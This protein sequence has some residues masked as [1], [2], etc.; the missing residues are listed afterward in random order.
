MPSI[1]SSDSNYQQNLTETEWKPHQLSIDPNQPQQNRLFELSQQTGYPVVQENGQRYA[2]SW[3]YASC[4][5]I[6]SC[7]FCLKAHHFGRIVSFYMGAYSKFSKANRFFLKR[8]SV[9]R[10]LKYYN[11]KFI[12]FRFISSPITLELSAI[13]EKKF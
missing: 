1:S 3:K 8:K 12:Y 2:K 7:N 11:Q 9:Q 5:N 4:V 10:F 6:S 13:E